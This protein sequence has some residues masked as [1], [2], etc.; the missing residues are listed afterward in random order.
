MPEDLSSIMGGGMTPS[1][2]GATG[3]KKLKKV[4]DH[5]EDEQGNKFSDEAGTQP[6]KSEGEQ[7]AEG[8][9]KTSVMGMFDTA[10]RLK[11]NPNERANVFTGDVAEKPSSVMGGKMPD[12]P[13]MSSDERSKAKKV[14][15]AFKSDWG[16]DENGFMARWGQFSDKYKKMLLDSVG[17]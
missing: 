14:Y 1:D 11:N 5:Y 17:G 16:V 6:M 12:A 10:Q 9:P 13:D 3:K 15:D 4:G 8:A 7:A 2:A